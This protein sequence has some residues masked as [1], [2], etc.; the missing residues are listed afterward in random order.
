MFNGSNEF[1]YFSSHRTYTEVWARAPADKF[2]GREATEKR[3]KNS[4]VKPLPRGG[5]K[6]AKKHR[7]IAKNDLK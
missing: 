1:F 6:A 5:G 3:P 7:K 4:T 2:P